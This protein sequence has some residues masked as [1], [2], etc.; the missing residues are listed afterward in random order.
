VALSLYVALKDINRNAMLAGAGFL[1]SFVI[2]DLAVTWPN[3][4]ALITLGGQYAAAANDVERTALVAAAYYPSAVLASIV[5]GVYAILV[6][7]LG[8]LIIGLVM[9]RGPFG[10]LTAHLAVTSGVLGIV[11]VVGPYVIR[12]L[13]LAI[14]IGSALT[15]AWVLLVGWRL[16]RLGHRHPEAAQ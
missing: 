6:P 1:V 7:S 2:L 8:N 9:R 13:G 14:V 12:A 10:R 15:T 16:Y 3:Y 5:V 11:A 4:A